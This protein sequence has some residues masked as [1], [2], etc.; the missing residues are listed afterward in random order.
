MWTKA[1]HLINSIS[2]GFGISGLLWF[3]I[4]GIMLIDYVEQLNF[5]VLSF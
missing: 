4:F 2:F 3:S 1:T 5:V